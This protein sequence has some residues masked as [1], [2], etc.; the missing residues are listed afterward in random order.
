[1]KPF[2]TLALAFTLTFAI[3]QG[4]TEAP[5]VDLP[6][7]H[8]PAEAAVA[9][10]ISVDLL[11]QP[12]SR[13]A[14]QILQNAQHTADAGD[15]ARAIG[16]L[17]MALVNYPESAAWTQSMLGVEY[18]KTKQF[19]AAVASLEQAILA[20]PR[21]AVNYSNLGFALASIGQYDRADP[22]LRRALALDHGNLKTRQLLDA[23][24]ANVPKRSAQTQLSAVSNLPS[25][26]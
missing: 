1:M 16:F 13:K 2:H 20:L 18:L 7:S 5:V 3:A 8:P 23:V 12:L 6:H 4:Q 15:H 14:K 24:L 17:K 26:R 10:T 22:E 11:S 25:S 9:R 21:E 19:A